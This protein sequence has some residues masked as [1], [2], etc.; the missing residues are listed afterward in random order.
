[1][2]GGLHYIIFSKQTTCCLLKN[3]QDVGQD[4]FQ[5]D[6][7][8]SIT[9]RTKDGDVLMAPKGEPPLAGTSEHPDFML[10]FSSLVRLCTRH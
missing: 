10:L 5:G 6:C 8:H 3:L 2:W 1:M 4:G 9:V 7:M